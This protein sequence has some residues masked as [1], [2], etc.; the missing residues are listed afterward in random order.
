[1]DL[2][3]DQLFIENGGLNEKLTG[4]IEVRIVKEILA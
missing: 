4:V 1:M 3:Y 2:N